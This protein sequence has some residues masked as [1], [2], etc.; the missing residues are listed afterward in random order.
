MHFIL[1]ETY[2]TNTYFQLYLKYL[3]SFLSSVVYEICV[4][5]VRVVK[6]NNQKPNFKMDSGGYKRTI[7]HS[8]LNTL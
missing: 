3:M 1:F 6:M 4:F 7:K 8:S 5:I 2:A